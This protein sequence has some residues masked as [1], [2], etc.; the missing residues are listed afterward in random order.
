MTIASLSQIADLNGSVPQHKRT[1]LSQYDFLNLLITQ[2]KYQ[3]PLNPMDYYQM[4]SMLTQFGSLEAL[5][6]LNQNLENSILYQ[7]SLYNLQ[8]AELIG[9]KIKSIGNTLSIEKGVVSE[10][11]Y[12]LAKPGKVS[13][14]II[15]SKGNVV[16][17]FEEEY[18]SATEHRLQWDGKD[19]T[20]N[21]LSDGVYYFNVSAVDKNGQPIPVTLYKE[22]K[23][24]GIRFENGII[25]LITKSDQITIKD[26]ISIME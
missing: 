4:T 16:R 11:Y 17:T 15:D 18:K 9:K 24:E 3:N 26:I 2:M 19:N 10:G 6:N 1:S 7:S 13:I 20:R 14:Q 22:D 23:I 5:Y 21:P 12:Q 25:Y 8:A